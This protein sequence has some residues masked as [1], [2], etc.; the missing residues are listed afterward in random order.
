MRLRQTLSIQQRILQKIAE[1]ENILEEMQHPDYPKEN[2]Q[3]HLKELKEIV[4]D[5]KRDLENE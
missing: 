2:I 1:V 4:R 5:L 3:E